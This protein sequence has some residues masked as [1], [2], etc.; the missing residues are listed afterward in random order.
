ILAALEA[1]AA[2]EAA[3]ACNTQNHDPLHELAFI[4]SQPV[5]V[6]VNG[7]PIRTFNQHPVTS[8]ELTAVVEFTYT[9][10]KETIEDALQRSFPP[11]ALHYRTA[12]ESYNSATST[13]RLNTENACLIIPGGEATELGTARGEMLT[14]ATY[15]PYR[16][17]PLMRGL[18]DNSA[19]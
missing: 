4:A 5:G 13:P 1:R 6:F 9:T 7:Y 11:A 18:R 10:V 16:S 12:M 19:I 2:K 8:V 14:N 17:R 3:D 15:T